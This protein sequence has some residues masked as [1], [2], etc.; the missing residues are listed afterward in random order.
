MSD[1]KGRHVFTFEQRFPRCVTRNVQLGQ[2]AANLRKCKGQKRCRGSALERQ[3]KKPRQSTSRTTAW[4]LAK[5]ALPLWS[6]LG[7][8]R[9]SWIFWLSTSSITWPFFSV[10]T[11]HTICPTL[12]TFSCF[13]VVE[14]TPS[15]EIVA[16]T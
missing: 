6:P 1:V 5:A 13:F 16:R 14:K 2:L 11:S 15:L 3:V 8:L 12:P 10:V 4:R 9:S 7:R